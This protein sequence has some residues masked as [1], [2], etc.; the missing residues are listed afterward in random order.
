MFDR[1]AGGRGRFDRFLDRKLRL[2]GALA[3]SFHHIHIAWRAYFWDDQYLP[4]GT[5]IFGVRID[6]AVAFRGNDPDGHRADIK[7]AGIEEPRSRAQRRGLRAGGP[8]RF[9]RSGPTLTSLGGV[10]ATLSFS[11]CSAGLGPG[12]KNAD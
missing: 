12:P 6:K 11:D 7:Y 2:D 3:L 9:A 5:P 4:G 8:C 10:R 1:S